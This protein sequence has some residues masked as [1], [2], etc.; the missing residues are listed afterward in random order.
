MSSNENNSQPLFCIVIGDDVTYKI[1]VCDD[2]DTSV[3]LTRWCIRATLKMDFNWT[4]EDPRTIKFDS[5]FLNGE[6]AENGIIH[7]SFS[8]NHTSLMK[9]GIYYFD[10]EAEVDAKVST[11][12]RSCIQAVNDVTKRGKN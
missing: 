2:D 1:V 7:I 5:G 12:V 6:D 8:S 9:A 3:D 4:D 10:V 11:I